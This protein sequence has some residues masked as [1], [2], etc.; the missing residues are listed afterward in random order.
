MAQEINIRS[1][2][3]ASK[4]AMPSRFFRKT[5]IIAAPLTLLLL[6]GCATPFRAEVARFQKLPATQG[7]SFAIAAFD[8]GDQGGIE[9][10]QYASLVSAKLGQL[11]Y[12]PAADAKTADLTVSLGYGVDGGRERIVSNGGFGHSGFGFGHSGF[13]FGHGFG[14]GFGRGFGHSGF[15]FG[16]GFGHSGFGFGRGFGHG[17]FGF[18]GGFGV[19][20]FTVYTGDIGINI[21]RNSDGK[22]LFEGKAQAQ[23]RSNRLPYLVPNLIEAMFT[24]FPGNSGEVVRI[25]VAP[26][27][28]S[29]K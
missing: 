8:P 28:K 1:P 29:K 18:G 23:S 4:G 14:R 6:A 19:D 7:Q 25:S 9:F 16:R 5:A 26:E 3:G 21:T 27:P 20:S 12:V 13:G 22:R 10:E 2:Q 24:D 17:G 15:G 11:G